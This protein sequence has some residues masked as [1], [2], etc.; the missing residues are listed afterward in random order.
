MPGSGSR[1]G[2]WA[3]SGSLIQLELSQQQIVQQERLRALGEMASGIAHDFNN[4]LSVVVQLHRL[5][6]LRPER[7]G[8]QGEG[9]RSAW[10]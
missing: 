6:L 8:R 5:L 3:S 10:G 9:E 1:S 2:S 7:S 4:A